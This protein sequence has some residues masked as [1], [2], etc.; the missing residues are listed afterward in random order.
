MSKT[1]CSTQIK[2]LT[3]YLVD[4]HMS[5][6]VCVFW[7]LS[8]HVDQL[9]LSIRNSQLQYGKTL[10]DTQFYI[11]NENAEKPSYN[12]DYLKKKDWKKFVDEIIED[13]KYAIE[14]RSEK[15]EKLEAERAENERK[16]Y[17]ELKAKF[18]TEPTPKKPNPIEKE[19]E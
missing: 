10:Y 15:L 5:G 13:I 17:E 12:E 14:Q 2:R 4:L 8:G 11:F 1:K 16:R 6:D 9:E 3:D 19:G 18:E 7:N